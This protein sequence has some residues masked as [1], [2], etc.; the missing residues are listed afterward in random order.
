MGREGDSLRRVSGSFCLVLWLMVCDGVA[1]RVLSSFG[2][3]TYIIVYETVGYCF[4]RSK[5][6]RLFCQQMLRPRFY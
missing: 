5:R 6:Q 2:L 1:R 3:Y 4:V